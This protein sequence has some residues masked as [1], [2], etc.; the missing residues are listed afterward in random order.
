VLD[1][2]DARA[3]AGSGAGAVV[4]S[5]HGGRQLDS[6]PS[7]ISALPAIVDVLAGRA[8]V[9]FDGGVRSGLDVFKA[10]AL[11]ARA[12]MAGRA[13]IF[14]LAALGQAGVARMLAT[15]YGELDVAMALS[16]VTAVAEIGRDALVAG[17]EGV[18][19]AP[20]PG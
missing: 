18:A 8:E 9:L 17:G 20:R 12:A 15:I 2:E 13:W 7:T 19:A 11:G 3:A 4:V 6:V 14:P 16:G 5:N 1:A 10:L